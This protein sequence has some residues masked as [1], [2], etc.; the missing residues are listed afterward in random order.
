MIKP[1]KHYKM[2][3]TAKTLIALTCKDADDRSVLKNMLIQ[4]ELA[5]ESARKQSL[6]AKSSNRNKDPAAAAD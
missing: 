5:A 1:D 2:S 3:S 4:S 6:K